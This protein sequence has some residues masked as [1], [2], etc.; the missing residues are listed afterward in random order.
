MRNLLSNAIKFTPV[1]GNIVVTIKFEPNSTKSAEDNKINGALVISVKDTGAG[2]S[3]ADQ[4][5]LFKEAVQFR[6]HE[7]QGGGGSGI[8]MMITKGI[9]DLHDGTIDVYSP[10]EG[11]GSTFTVRIPITRI[12]TSST[13]TMEYDCFSSKSSYHKLHENASTSDESCNSKKHIS[14]SIQYFSV[15]LNLLIFGDS[16]MS[17]NMMRRVLA[18]HGHLVDE[19]ENEV[20]AVETIKREVLKLRVSFVHL[21]MQVRS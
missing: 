9:V 12:F 8:G 11:L 6:P 18:S 4:K 13:K 2:M 21:D 14:S 5:R 17:R 15:N 10:G 20:K 1:G 16:V 7:L 19:A 3:L